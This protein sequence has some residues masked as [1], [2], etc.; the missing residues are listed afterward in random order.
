MLLIRPPLLATGI[1]ASNSRTS[2]RF[3]NAAPPLRGSREKGCPGGTPPKGWAGTKLA[4]IWSGVFLSARISGR[5]WRKVTQDQGIVWL[6]QSGTLM[7]LVSKLP[8]WNPISTRR[9][10]PPLPPPQRKAR[11]PAD[12]GEA[13]VMV[14]LRKSDDRQAAQLPT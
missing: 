4:W 2:G 6:N 9:F 11:L 10:S 5:T 13:N 7:V 8:P 1:T 3:W 14:L 12:V